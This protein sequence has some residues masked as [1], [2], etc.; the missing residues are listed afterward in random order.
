PPSPTCC[1]NTDYETNAYC[2]LWISI[3]LIFHPS[4]STSVSEERTNCLDATGSLPDGF[5]FTGLPD[6]DTIPCPCCNDGIDDGEV[7]ANCDG[8]GYKIIHEADYLEANVERAH[9][10]RHERS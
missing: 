3:H 6:G 1:K 9:E 8:D 4:M 2:P 5:E 10:V 7:C